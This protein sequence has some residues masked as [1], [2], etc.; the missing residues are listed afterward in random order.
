[1]TGYSACG[2]RRAGRQIWAVWTRKPQSRS[3]RFLGVEGLQHHTLGK[4]DDVQHI[5]NLRRPVWARSRLITRARW[6]DVSFNDRHVPHCLYRLDESVT[7]KYSGRSQRSRADNLGHIMPVSR[8]SSSAHSR[9]LARQQTRG[10]RCWTP[11][12]LRKAVAIRYPMAP[13][14][15]SWFS[16][17]QRDHCNLK[18]PGFVSALVKL[19]R[20]F[21]K[22]IIHLSRNDV[23]PHR[24]EYFKPWPYHRC[25]CS[26]I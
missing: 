25:G 4:P 14:P 15:S 24:H 9:W 19:I 21:H 7:M 5:Q 10:F 2:T 11:H 1:M 8:S 16:R 26:A 3:C 23:P 22:S 20:H 17:K 13:F 12:M 6:H 18:E